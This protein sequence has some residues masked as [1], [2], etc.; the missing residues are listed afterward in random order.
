MVNCYFWDILSLYDWSLFLV[1]GVL[2]IIS[3]SFAVFCCYCCAIGKYDLLF[4]F[5]GY[6]LG[7][8]FFGVLLMC[9]LYR[10]PKLADCLNL[11]PEVRGSNP[12]STIFPPMQKILISAAKK[13]A[14]DKK[15]G[16][17][18]DQLP[19]G[20]LVASAECRELLLLQSDSD[21][22]LDLAGHWIWPAEVMRDARC[23][24]SRIVQNIYNTTRALSNLPIKFCGPQFFR[25]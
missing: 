17:T 9:V 12:A 18:R 25:Q 21:L 20:Q 3:F 4:W 19:T 14:R 15:K 11:H 23:A 7:G 24:V 1:L 22:G 2:V 8:R 10:L 5:S 16:G 6:D 13:N